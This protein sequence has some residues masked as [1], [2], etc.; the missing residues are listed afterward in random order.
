MAHK[1]YDDILRNL[2]KLNVNDLLGNTRIGDRKNIE[3]AVE[4]LRGG[5]SQTQQTSE[6]LQSVER[7]GQN[8]VAKLVK[9]TSQLRGATNNDKVADLVQE[10]TAVLQSNTSRTITKD[11]FKF[12]EG[13]TKQLAD[14]SVFE[15]QDR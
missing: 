8:K 9:L 14:P 11:A 12:L 1:Q 6:D 15:A 7:I 10:F 4:Q 5:S 3:A 2:G 13:L